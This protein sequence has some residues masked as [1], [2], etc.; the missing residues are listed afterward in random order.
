MP[1][2]S[3]ADPPRAEWAP[4]QRRPDAADAE[5]RAKAFLEKMV[6]PR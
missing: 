6:K 2:P 3:A 1:S 5:E 4:A